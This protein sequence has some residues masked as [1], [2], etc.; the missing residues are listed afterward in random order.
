MSPVAQTP[1]PAPSLPLSS[2]PFQA[3]EVID[4]CPNPRY[5]THLR[6]VFTE[7]IAEQQ[8]KA[9]QQDRLKAECK[10]NAQKVKQNIM[11]YSWTSDNTPPKV[12]VTQAFTWPFL[13]LLLALLSTIGLQDAGERGE[14]CFYDEVDA[15]NW[16]EVDVGHT[17]KLITRGRANHAT[18]MR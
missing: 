13:S 15:L 12:W 2:N 17:E 5:T 3:N 1:P 7:V 11:L 18:R 8:E 9:R 4:A 10:A 16:V 14:L 6:P